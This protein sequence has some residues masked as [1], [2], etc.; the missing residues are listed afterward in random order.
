MLK[1]MS[2]GKNAAVTEVED[3]FENMSLTEATSKIINLC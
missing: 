2:C 1:E 3:F